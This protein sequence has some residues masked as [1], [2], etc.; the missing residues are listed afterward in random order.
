MKHLV[1]VGAGFAGFWAA[2][3]A[4]RYARQLGRRDAIRVSVFE[5]AAHH[6]IRPRYY[7][8]DPE[9]AR[10]PLRAYFDPLGIAHLQERIARIEPRSR[11]V[12][13]EGSD[14]PTHFDAMIL[15]AGSGIQCPLAGTGVF[16]VSRL[17][18]AL[19]LAGRLQSL[20]ASTRRSAAENA[21]AVVG[22]GLSGLE[23]ATRI[24][25]DPECDWPGRAVYLVDSHP[26]LAASYSPDAQRYIAHRMEA[27][28]IDVVLG[29]RV[30]A[31]ANDY[32][33][34]AGGKLIQAA[35]VVWAGGFAASPLATQLPGRHDPLGRVRVDRM[36]RVEGEGF[37]FAAGD[38]AAATVDGEHFAPMSCQH[39]IPQGK[40]AGHN[41]VA[42]LFG[43]DA[44]KY[45]QP[46]YV[47]CLDL[48]GED[49]LFTTGW[50][51]RLDKVGPTA[52]SLKRK[53]LN[54][55]IYPPADPECA[56]AASDPSA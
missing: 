18:G 51:R 34:L 13:A 15:A 38:S 39:A 2:M 41:A 26:Q 23:L 42:D 50:E 54:E 22:A 9:A 32:L 31:Y 27:L 6:G 3:S 14:A 47:T 24:A 28:G 40:V 45:S 21:I 37:I 17:E 36:L 20:R 33:R 12:W 1:I 55:W 8:S 52:K 11:A 49:A 7:E 46:H 16:E 30:E 48:G 10:V 53:I 43:G 19:R 56:V 35:T 5:P 25:T 4:I 44:V 29:H